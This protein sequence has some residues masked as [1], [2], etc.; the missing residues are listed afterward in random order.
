MLAVIVGILTLPFLLNPK[1]KQGKTQPPSPRPLLSSERTN[2]TKNTAIATIATKTKNA[3]N[4]T[5]AKRTFSMPLESWYVVLQWTA[6]GLIGLTFLVG[7][8]TVWVGS[9]VNKMQAAQLKELRERQEPHWV[10][11]VK[12]K[13]LPFLKDK[14]KGTFEVLVVDDNPEAISFAR[15]LT[16]QLRDDAGW[17]FKRLRLISA[18]DP[19]QM[20]PPFTKEYKVPMLTKVGGGSGISITTNL[21]FSAE[22]EERLSNE[23]T[24]RH[25]LYFALLEA[26]F[27]V[28]RSQDPRLPDDVVRIVIGPQP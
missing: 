18:D 15:T 12:G 8:A 13:L 19:S 17:Y 7:I 1:R 16:S 14:P 9:R 24:P 4:K 22:D 27:A 26:G 11:L 2:L 23:R 28:G 3:I 5:P 20:I 10:W 6:A 25:A 21:G